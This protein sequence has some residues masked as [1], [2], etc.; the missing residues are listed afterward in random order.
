MEENDPPINEDYGISD[1]PPPKRGGWGRERPQSDPKDKHYSEKG[2]HRERGAHAK[3]RERL[4]RR[5]GDVIP[6]R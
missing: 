6:K 2:G 3:F 4:A 1:P 5:N